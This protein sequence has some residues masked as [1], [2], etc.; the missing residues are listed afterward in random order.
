MYVGP[1]RLSKTICIDYIMHTNKRKRPNYYYTRKKRC[2]KGG[3]AIRNSLSPDTAFAHFLENSSFTYFDRGFF[4]VLVLATL[5]KGVDSNYVSVRLS[6]S[7]PV[8]RTLLIKLIKLEK[9]TAPRIKV[10]TPDDVKREIS[11]QQE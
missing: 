5:K 10:V 9:P 4:G 2:K 11:I 8:V 7:E 6:S 1:D 3:G